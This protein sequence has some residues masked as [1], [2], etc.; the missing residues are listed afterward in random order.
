MVFANI[1]GIFATTA[2][3]AEFSGG[4]RSDGGKWRTGSTLFWLRSSVT[5]LENKNSHLPFVAT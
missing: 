3:F 1:P 5:T 4:E 2:Y